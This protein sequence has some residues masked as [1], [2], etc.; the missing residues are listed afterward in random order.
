MTTDLQK[1]IADLLSVKKIGFE[2][3]E[4]LVAPAVAMSD[5]ELVDLLKQLEPRA[6][7]KLG[8]ASPILV[9]RLSEI[10]RNQEAKEVDDN[11]YERIY[12][13]D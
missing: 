2:H 5:E 8:E 9:A 7:A 11:R 1:V 12:N 10:V 6:V 3:V 13:D 4:P